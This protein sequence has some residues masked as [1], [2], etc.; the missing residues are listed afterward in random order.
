MLT[1]SMTNPS[2]L[3]AMS[4]ALLTISLLSPS[5][6]TGETPEKSAVDS[7][8]D[9]AL[10]DRTKF[11]DA[12]RNCLEDR[13]GALCDAYGDPE[14]QKP[15]LLECFD[16]ESPGTPPIKIFFPLSP[17]GTPGEVDLSN[18]ELEYKIGDIIKGSGWATSDSLESTAFKICEEDLAPTLELADDPNI[19]ACKQG[20]IHG[21]KAKETA[22]VAEQECIA[23][24]KEMWARTWKMKETID[25]AIEGIRG[26]S[27]NQPQVRIE[28]DR[29]MTSVAVTYNTP[30]DTEAQRKNEPVV[31]VHAF[32]EYEPIGLSKTGMQWNT[33]MRGGLN[34]GILQSI[35]AG[36]YP[37]CLSEHII[38]AKK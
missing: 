6:S 12:I 28:L 30:E 35:G 38:S 19:F 8:R 16:A 32:S 21:K 11:A 26:A 15:D 14:N 36:C 37:N 3:S 20:K 9:T 1:I 25:R 33:F 7:P 34:S 27:S 10:K 13:F 17:W 29:S 24:K 18:P 22:A 5:S 23:Q 4:G 2:R 31:H